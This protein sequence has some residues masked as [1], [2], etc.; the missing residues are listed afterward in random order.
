MCWL[1]F[2][3]FATTYWRFPNCF[4]LASCFLFFQ[5]LPL[6]K[7]T[8]NTLHIPNGSIRY[9]WHEFFRGG[10]QTSIYF[11]LTSMF[12]INDL[13]KSYSSKVCP[14]RVFN[15]HRKFAVFLLISDVVLV[16]CVANRTAVVC[17]WAPV[18]LVQS[19]SLYKS[20]LLLSICCVVSFL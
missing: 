14:Y 10:R 5:I 4:L 9:K 16:R 8:R 13:I 15:I 19:K 20:N 2:Q 3:N 18:M 7:P 12:E 1:D 6:V 11:E 17:T